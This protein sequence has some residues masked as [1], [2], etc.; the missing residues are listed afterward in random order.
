MSAR[1]L[2]HHAVKQALCADGW[3]I[4]DDP[5]VVQFGGVDLYIDL[6]AEKLLQVRRWQILVIG[7]KLNPAGNV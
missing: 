5:L 1:D 3:T 2:F 7:T 4:T 6:G